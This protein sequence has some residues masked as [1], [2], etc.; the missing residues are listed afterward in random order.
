MC[1]MEW[2]MYKCRNPRGAHSG[3]PFQYVGWSG[4]GAHQRGGTLEAGSLPRQKQL[5]MSGH[6]VLRDARLH[7]HLVHLEGRLVDRHARLVIVN[8]AQDQVHTAAPIGVLEG[9]DEVAETVDGADVG[10][11]ALKIHVRV[12]VCQGLDSGGC[13][14]HA[15]LLWAEK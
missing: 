9:L 15:G 11:V 5:D 3:R 8:A 14:G 1:G 6:R 7:P 4:I 10:M 2:Y 12:D 13:F